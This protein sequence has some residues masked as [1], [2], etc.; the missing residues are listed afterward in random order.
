MTTSVRPSRV[1]RQPR[2]PA[3]NGSQQKLEGAPP[4]AGSSIHR[5]GSKASAPSPQ[6]CGLRPRAYSRRG[7]A[8]LSKRR[9]LAT[10]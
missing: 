2:G 4:P 9:L 1:L 7:R 6:L 8:P 10:F 5:C 3:P